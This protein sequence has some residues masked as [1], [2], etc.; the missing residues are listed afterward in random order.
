TDARLLPQHLADLRKSGLSDEQIR[1]CGFHSLQAPARIQKA[2]NWKRYNGQLGDCLA[3][4]FLDAEGKL[5]E[6]VRLKPDRPRKDKEGKAQG[7]RELI[8]DLAPIAWQGRLVPLCFDSD[9]ATNP[10]VRRAEWDLAETLR[11]HGAIVRIVRL[12][13]G[14]PGPDGTPA[15][16]GLDDF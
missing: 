1:W 14:D 5:T 13:A 11:R 9:A 4:P 3:F 2:L 10:N 8:D 15:K 6:Y 7:E 16:V 12:P